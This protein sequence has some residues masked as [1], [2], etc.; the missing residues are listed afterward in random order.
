MNFLALLQRTKRKCRVTGAIPT[1][2]MG[3]NEEFARLADFVNEAWMNLQL[4]RADW[5]W[6]RA[7][8]SFPVVLGQST[9]TLAQIQSTGTGL[10]NFGNWDVS[11]FRNYDTNIGT[12]SEIEIGFIPYDWWRDTYQINSMRRTNSRPVQFTV[13]PTHGIALGPNPIAGYTISGDYHKVASEMSA[14]TDT[15]L[16]PTQFHMALVYGAMMS[17]GVSES[18]PEIYDEGEKEYTRMVRS[19]EAHQLP[20]L[21]VSGA[22]A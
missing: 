2:V 6:M 14:N 17:Y 10:S 1:S 8:M 12:D 3:Q 19:I 7:S 22:L 11:T 21:T 5:R 13:T 9:Y 16:L 20:D 15:P 4:N 18:K